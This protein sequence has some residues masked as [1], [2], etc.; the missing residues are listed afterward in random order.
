M[1]LV[2]QLELGVDT[3]TGRV[4]TTN[5]D[6]YLV[7]CPADPAARQRSGELFVIADGMGGAS[8]GAE[9][10]RAAVRALAMAFVDGQ[11]GEEPQARMRRAFAAACQRLYR[12]GREQPRLRDMGTTLTAVNVL[13]DRMVLGHVGDTRCYVLRDDGLRQLTV[14]HAVR[15]AEHQLVRCVGAGREHEVADVEEHALAAGDVLLLA[16]DGLWD[17]VAPETI[18]QVLRRRSAQE[19]A[20]ELVRLAV[21][22]GGVDNATALVLRVRDAGDGALAEVDPP[23]REFVR[24]PPLHAPLPT[25]ARPLW[26]WLA[27]GLA[28]TGA[29]LVVARLV[30][31][32]DLLRPI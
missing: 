32:V 17:A 4:R 18:L 12:L 2:Q 27:F 5:E 8:G 24:L 14:D 3:H 6:D 11:G 25:L 21:A 19:A 7:Y 20:Q 10:S 28:L 16:T 22:A 29:A 9:A 15:R 1:N 23:V 30:F 26:P 13:G 31:G